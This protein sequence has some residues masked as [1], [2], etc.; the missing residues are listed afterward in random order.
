MLALAAKVQSGGNEV[1]FISV[2]DAEA[3]AVGAGLR[4]LGVGTDHLPLGS[5]KAVE[6][7]FGTMQGEEGLKFTFDLMGMITGALI[8]PVEIVLASE[9][10]E[11]VVFDTY[12]PY[13]E[14]SALALN[15]RCE[16][17]RRSTTSRSLREGQ[18]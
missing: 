16:P 13:M 11:G 12:Q 9:R 1:V 3:R 5:T 17:N 15:L 18:R 7:Q 4:F 14:L 8:R 2:V 6:Q 10:V